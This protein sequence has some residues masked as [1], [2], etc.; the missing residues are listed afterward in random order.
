MKERPISFSTSLIQPI[1]NGVKTMT[2]RLLSDKLIINDDP[3]RYKYIGYDKG[4]LFEDLKP[5]IT[6]WITPIPS[7]FGEIGDQLWI[8][9]E[10]KIWAV[11]N[12]WYCQFKDGVII[13]LYYKEISLT[14]LQKLRKRKTLG[15]WQR[16][17]FLPKVFA[18]TWIEITDVKA[19]RLASISADD[20]VHEGIEV[21][22]S[23]PE[24]PEETRYRWYNHPYGGE[25]GTN[26]PILSFFTLW[27]SIQ[28]ENSV[29]SNPWVWVIG[30]EVIIKS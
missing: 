5:E 17:R 28:G 6:P 9:E 16:A 13:D 3:D 18:R 23:W 29:K 24:A 1:H 21:L 14:T 12:R 11:E 10:H 22:P 27:A 4:L 19:D 20:A 15:K 2:R 8:R 26:D 7:P 30:F 25:V